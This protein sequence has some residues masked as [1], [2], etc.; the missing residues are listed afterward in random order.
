M[1]LLKRGKVKDIYELDDKRLVFEFTDRISAFDIVLPSTI[2]RKGEILCKFAEYW[3]NTL[4][5]PNHMLEVRPPNRMVVKKLNLIPIECVIRGYLYGSLYERVV[6]KEINLET[7][8]LAA[9]L[10]APYF[11][12][13]TKFEEK[14]R[15]V[16]RDEILQ[17]GW[18]SGEKFQ[19]IKQQSIRIYK[20]VS[21]HAEKAGF[22]LADLKI[23]F[24]HDNEGKILLADSIGPDEFRLWPE[25]LY[26]PGKSQESY[27]KQPIR[28]W[29][30]KIGYRKKLEE[31]RETNNPNPEPP[32]LPEDLINE[33]T[34]RYITAYE[35]LTRRRF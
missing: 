10:P 33:V 22:V 25:E 21:L 11:D 8:T 2:P 24:G 28:D 5:V 35:K 30:I 13:T 9:A 27:D 16:T 32:L 18:L 6:K 4:E 3:F 1:K 15:P 29:L 23:E 12:P 19:W 7:S 34:R 20:D 14:D 31:A 17:K 26:Q